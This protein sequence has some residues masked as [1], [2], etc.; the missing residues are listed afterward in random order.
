MKQDLSLA[1]EEQLAIA[2]ALYRFAAGQDLRDPAL[3][4]SAFSRDAELDFV[5]PARRLG[6]EI[7]PFRGRAEILDAIHGALAEV[8]TTHTVTN[9]RIEA[10]GDGA[11]LFALVEAQHL[12]RADHSR[13][14]LLKN[15]YWVTLE[16]AGGRW[17]IR[18]MR[19][20]NSWYR[21]D[22][23]VLFPGATVS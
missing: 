23:T 9:L 3:L 20:N 22:P 5:Q 21:G 19:V 1:A 12:P 13:N 18:R 7:A 8:D 14:L 10:E 2:D 15:F 16:R 6:V 11:S 4:S 17:T